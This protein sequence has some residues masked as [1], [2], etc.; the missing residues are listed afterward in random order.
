MKIWLSNT[1]KLD[2]LQNIVTNITWTVFIYS[3]IQKYNFLMKI[4][5]ITAWKI[6]INKTS[7]VFKYNLSLGP[8]ELGKCSR[9]C[10][11]VYL[12]VLLIS[13]PILFYFRFQHFID[14]MFWAQYSDGLKIVNHINIFLCRKQVLLCF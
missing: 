1:Y 2:N 4:K 13:M 5:S 9:S 12:L 7:N 14:F 10:N 8:K 6:L 3:M 11:A